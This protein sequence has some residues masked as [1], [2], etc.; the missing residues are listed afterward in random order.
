MSDLDQLM[1]QALH[2]EAAPADPTGV[3]DAVRRRLATGDGGVSAAAAGPFA[4]GAG[5]LGWIGAGVLAVV[6]GGTAGLV[7]LPGQSETADDVSGIVRAAVGLDCPGG[8]PVVGFGSGERVLAVA[9]SADASHLAVRSPFDRNQI[10]WVATGKVTPDG[11]ADVVSA[12]P[13]KG[14]AEGQVTALPTQRE[15][16]APGVP[17]STPPVAATSKPKTDEPP[18]EDEPDEPAPVNHAPKVTSLKVSGD[19]WCGSNDPAHYAYVDV[20]AT[21]DH[22]V[23]KVKISWSGDDSGSAWMTKSGGGWKYTYQPPATVFDVTFTV[24]AHDAKGRTST[25]KSATAS[26]EC[27]I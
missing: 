7:G 14:C 19:P 13:E 25:P 4:K 22:G 3:V 16:K 9:R 23:T 26:V 6:V 18:A 10:V 11:G 27:L 1:R 8:S 21:D 24:R 17:T 12:L 2:H 5:F 20:A 15:T